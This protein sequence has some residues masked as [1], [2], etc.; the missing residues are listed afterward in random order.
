MSKFN[1]AVFGNWD[2]TL[3]GLVGGVIMYL[4]QAGLNLPTDKEGAKGLAIGAAMLW[5]GAQAKS[6][7]V[8]SQAK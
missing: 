7:N 2:T 6:A 5:L 8:G 1:N 3:A 4:N